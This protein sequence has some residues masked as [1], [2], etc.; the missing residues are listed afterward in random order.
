MRPP[1]S[2]AE[3]TALHAGPAEAESFPESTADWTR[4]GGALRA[5][6]KDAAEEVESLLRRLPETVTLEEI[7]RDYGRAYAECVKAFPAL[8]EGRRGRALRVRAYPAVL[9]A[10][11]STPREQL[12]GPGAS[13]LMR[14]VGDAFL[15]AYLPIVRRRRETAYGERQRDF[16]GVTASLS[17]SEDFPAPGA[18]GIPTTSPRPVCGKT[19]LINSAASAA[20]SST[21]EIA[22][23]T[24]RASPANT[25]SI[26]S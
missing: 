14:A 4:A 10:L 6:A 22:R 19:A 11:E 26:N 9:E 17:T 24:A 5:G 13:W 25:R 18:P 3:L 21:L 16:T 7:E 20:P 8:A 1:V 12:S 23:A 2:T 15:P